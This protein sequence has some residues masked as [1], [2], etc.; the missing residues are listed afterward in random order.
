MSLKKVASTP[1]IS[2]ANDGGDASGQ[3]G[4]PSTATWQR[5][6]LR[7]IGQFDQYAAENEDDE[8]TGVRPALDAHSSYGSTRQPNHSAPAS[9]G[10]SNSKWRRRRGLGAIPGIIIPSFSAS[11]PVSPGPQTAASFTDHSCLPTQRPLSAYD[12]LVVK[13][14]TDPN[15][16]EADA[17]TNGIRVWYSS[18]TSID[19]LHDAI[20]DSTRQYRLR[21]HKSKRGRIFR[22]LDR[23]IGWIVVT[24]VGFLTAVVAFMIIRSEQW[25][26]DLKYGYCKDGVFKALRFCCHVQDEVSGTLLPLFANVILEETCPEW[27]T[28]A[29]FFAPMT[30][31]QGGWLWLEAE[32]IEYLAY[33][34]IAVRLLSPDPPHSEGNRSFLLRWCWLLRHRF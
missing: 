15:E 4:G 10:K 6:G 19:W 11:T 21:R 5:H 20:K 13:G 29:E 16:T 17:R 22:Q 26:F 7:Q 28:W 3:L 31:G 33:A 2:E 8:T 12:A 32:I 14:G 34:V 9:S 23:S 30:K 18:F 1:V 25:L 24:I 27:K